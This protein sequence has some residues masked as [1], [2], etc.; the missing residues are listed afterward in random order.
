MFCPDCGTWNRG[1]A[2]ICVRCAHE[3]PELADAPTE[4]PDEEMDLV[5]RATGTRYRIY[6]RVGSG[7]MAHV[8]RGATHRCSDVR[9]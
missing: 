5:R 9:S 8:Y 6:R 7:G 4:K 2:V 3:L 1:M